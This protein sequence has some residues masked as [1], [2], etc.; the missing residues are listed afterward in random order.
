MRKGI[1]I[2]LGPNGRNSGP[3]NQ[4]GTMRN[5]T[6]I[7]DERVKVWPKNQNIIMNRNILIRMCES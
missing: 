3:C 2:F 6:I 7:G 5:D 1:K 4:L